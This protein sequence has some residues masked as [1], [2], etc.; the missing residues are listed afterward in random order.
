MFSN[1]KCKQTF[2]ESN[3][4][5]LRSIGQLS[6]EIWVIKVGIKFSFRSHSD[7]FQFS[8]PQRNF[9]SFRSHSE[10]FQFSE[11]Q[12]LLFQFSEPQRLLFQ[13]SEPQRNYFSF[14][15]HSDFFLV[16]GAIATFFSFRSH[17]E[18]FLVFGAI[19][20]FLHIF[21]TFCVFIRLCARQ[22]ALSIEAV[23]V[24]GAQSRCTFARAQRV[25]KV[26]RSG[27]NI[28]FTL[29]RNDKF[30]SC[31]IFGWFGGRIF[32]PIISIR[33]YVTLF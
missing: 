9:F 30:K 5:N 17:S 26:Q 12:R 3:G 20:L 29:W 14:R 1:K 4:T 28:G 15:S 6:R 33:R 25:A 23:L 22:G 8:E 16:F 19:A 10:I 24:M 7:F 2:K 18:N 11:P 31:T 21:A 27:R 32:T 13:F